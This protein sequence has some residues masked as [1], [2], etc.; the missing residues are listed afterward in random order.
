MNDY[1][2][3]HHGVL[4]MKWGIHRGAKSS[5][6]RHSRTDSWS[7]DAK[8]ANNLSKKSVHQM[9]NDELR[10]LNNRSQLEQQ[11]H[12]LNPGT[13]GKGVKYMAAAGAIMGTAV[14]VY[15]NGSK[16]VS[17]G[18][19][20]SDKFG[21]LGIAAMNTADKAYARHLGLL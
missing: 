4:G 19:M 12:Q 14:A 20:A 8:T 16:L 6:S 11:Y 5:S 15:N 17:V 3:Y 13:I 7:P 2:L 21:K 9:S 10:S 18:K 1:E